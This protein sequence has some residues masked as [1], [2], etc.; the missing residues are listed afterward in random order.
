MPL[1]GAVINVPSLG[2]L[3][4][5]SAGCVTVI[6]AGSQLSYSVIR[7][8]YP[9]YDYPV[10]NVVVVKFSLKPNVILSAF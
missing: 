8:T 1:F 10:R 3:C 4:I 9:V 7:H 6:I 2:F 5:G